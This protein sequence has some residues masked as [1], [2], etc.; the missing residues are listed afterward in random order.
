VTILGTLVI[1]WLVS[2]V[3]PAWTTRYL[4][5]L[6]GPMLLIAALGLARAG[7]LGF[8]A[9]AIILAIW[10]IPRS[11]GLENKSNASDLRKAVVPELHK[12]DLVVSMQPE[13]GPLLAYHLETLG[14]APK[15]RFAS[16][17]G[18]VKNDRVMDWT[19]GYDK[20]KAAT[21]AKNLAP[22]LASLPA[23]GRVLFVYPVTSRADDWDAPW[24]EY[25]RRRAA[26]WGEALAA[27]KR[28]ELVGAVPPNY[29]RATR[30]G[31]RGVVYEKKAESG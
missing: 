30:I 31:V 26:Q 19:D 12:G 28:F 3:S 14:G 7:T 27:D 4:G 16:P 2:Q 13:Q 5:V 10:A 24:T 6:L 21:P 8:V 29:R 17:L 1:A 23:G 11:Y 15:L 18:A 9:L 22:L 25:V 20:L